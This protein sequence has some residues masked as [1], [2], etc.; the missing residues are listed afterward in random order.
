MEITTA[1]ENKKSLTR[2]HTDHFS[3]ENSTSKQLPV[4]YLRF[5]TQVCFLATIGSSR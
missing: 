3:K 5:Q 4:T 1:A 2:G